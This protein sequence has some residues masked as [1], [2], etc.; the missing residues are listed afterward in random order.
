[1]RPK[2]VEMDVLVLIDE[3]ADAVRNAKRFGRAGEVRV[4]KGRTYDIVERM[5]ATVPGAVN[6]ARWVVGEREELVVEAKLEA[7]RILKETREHQ[8][9]LITESAV[10]RSAEREAEMIVAGAHARERE[11]RLGAESYTD[12]IVHAL[13]LN[14]QKLTAAVQRRRH[15]LTAAI[16][17]RSGP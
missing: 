13:E 8:A 15:M 12:D 4:D 16:E 2:G 11:I 3:L 14:L 5:R 10:M 17:R 1:M 9:R 7:E 6:Q